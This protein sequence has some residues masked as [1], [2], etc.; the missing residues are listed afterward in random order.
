MGDQK[1]HEMDQRHHEDNCMTWRVLDLDLSLCSFLYD[2]WSPLD[3]KPLL[4]TKEHVGI[5]WKTLEEKVKD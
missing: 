1:D 4:R 3:M 5:V 2:F